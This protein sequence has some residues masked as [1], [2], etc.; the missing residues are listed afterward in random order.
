M[1]PRERDYTATLTLR[2]L[3]N[4]ENLDLEEIQLKVTVY[5]E[6]DF[7]SV[8]LE[9]V[10]LIPDL[11]LKYKLEGLASQQLAADQ[12]DEADADACSRAEARW[13]LGSLL[14]QGS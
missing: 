12:A 4:L 7:R 14:H 6:D 9:S 3:G 1:R 11:D 10:E 2:D 8:S 13:D 5:V